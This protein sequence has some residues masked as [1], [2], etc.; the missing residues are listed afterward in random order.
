MF[1]ACPP[2]STS[3]TRKYI[4]SPGTCGDGDNDGERASPIPRP[5]PPSCHARRRGTSPLPRPRGD[6]LPVT[7]AGAAQWYR[8]G[9]PRTRTFGGPF[10]SPPCRALGVGTPRGSRT[11]PG[12]I[13]CAGPRPRSWRAA[14]SRGVR[15]GQ[16]SQTWIPGRRSH[17][18]RS[19][20]PVARRIRMSPPAS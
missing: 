20:R 7:L 3:Q 14:P 11:A 12:R 5:R 16:P 18:P 1:T 17:A 4:H 19:R 13:A 8:I 6:N 9:C 2:S 15:P 10:S